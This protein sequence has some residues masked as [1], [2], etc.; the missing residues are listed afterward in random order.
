MPSR[1]PLQYLERKRIFSPQVRHRPVFVANA[2]KSHFRP[3][4]HHPDMTGPDEVE[5]RVITQEE[6]RRLPYE[7]TFVGTDCCT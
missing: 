1:T 7:P 2:Q 6:S 3:I 5:D 4:I